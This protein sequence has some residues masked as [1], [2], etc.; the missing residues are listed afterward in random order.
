MDAVGAASARSRSMRALGSFAFGVLLVT[1]GACGP[2][3]A[4]KPAAA[5]VEAAPAPKPVDLAQVLGRELEAQPSHSVAAA[6]GSFSATM[7]ASGAPQPTAGEG[8]TRITAPLG[9]AQL[10]CFVYPGLKDAGELIRVLVEQT[11]KKAAPDHQWIDVRGDQVS[12]RAYVAARAHYWVA[13][14]Q[15]KLAGDFKVAAS[16][17]DQ[18][19]VAC[20]LD[21]PGLYASFERSLRSLLGS[22][23]VA[24]SRGA[25]KPQEVSITRSQVAGRMVNMT[26]AA[27]T[28]KG[29]EKTVVTL[30]TTL[31]LG[32]EGALVTADSAASET[33][34]RGKL[35]E[36]SYASFAAGQLA[37]KLAL[38]RSHSRYKV[39][40]TLKD[41]PA[42]AEFVVQGGIMDGER[43][44]A[45]VCKVRD[46]KL[47]QAELVAYTPS[48]DP[49]NTA[50][51]LVTKSS[52]PEADVVAK[53]QGDAGE[54]QVKLDESCDMQNGTMKVGEL[55]VQL[56]RLHHEKTKT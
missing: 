21:A 48:V 33:F 38:Q 53:V 49:L 39:T 30:S 7:Q 32:A 55:N 43:S 6:D 29:G 25:P 23:D 18:S 24:A 26:R 19:T 31:S 1:L 8:F 9:D 54:V 4:P 3:P 14:P 28:V 5:P 11:L 47:P 45:E 50:T 36:G 13:G 46:G 34:V 16:A 27:T 51:T 42:T 17:F 40:G 35:N 22:L 20:L 12:G 37:Y 2:R 41:S 44:N 15:G 56:E 10:V 52:T